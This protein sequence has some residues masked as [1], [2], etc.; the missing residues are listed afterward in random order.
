MLNVVHY[1]YA[2]LVV[3]GDFKDHVNYFCYGLLVLELFRY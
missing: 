1:Y 2:R 3:N